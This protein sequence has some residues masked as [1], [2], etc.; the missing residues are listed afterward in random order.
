MTGRATGTFVRTAFMGVGAAL[1]HSAL[2]AIRSS[3]QAS[4]LER[5]NH[6]GG[7][8]SLAA[9]PAL[10]LAASSAAGAGAM[11]AREPGLAGACL[12]AGVGAGAIGLYDDV[13]GAR[14]DEKRIK[15]FAGHL[16]ALREGRVTTGLVK[17]V[18]IGVV[19]LAAASALP[20]RTP[21][22]RAPRGRAGR[23]IDVG[24]AAG[25]IAGTANLVN[26]LDLRPGRALKAGIAVAAPLTTGQTG[27]AAAGLVGAASALLPADLGEEVMLGDGGANALGALLGVLAARRTGRW[28]RAVL[29]AGLGALTAA[30]ERVSF[31]A[32]IERTPVLRALDHLGRKA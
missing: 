25:V 28:G 3:G 15:G 13:A 2:A 6:R 23:M 7:T 31:T 14:P 16:G 29:L 5:V 20:V 24:L 26:L 9:G 21:P 30:S 19:G 32:V 11:V 18:G 22:G 27:P 10:A 1:A 8:V 17:I 4:R 12:V